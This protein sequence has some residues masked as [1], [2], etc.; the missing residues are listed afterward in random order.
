MTLNTPTQTR[1]TTIRT[2]NIASISAAL[3]TA[4]VTLRARS[5][6]IE[7]QANPVLW[8]HERL[9]IG[10]WSKQEEIANSIVVN[11]K[12]AVKSCNGVGKTFIAAVLT[13]WWID[14]HHDNEVLVVTTAPTDSQVKKLLW[15]YIRTIHRQFG[16]RGTVS[17]SAEWKSGDRDFIAYG[18]KPADTNMVAFQGAHTKYLLAIIDEAGGVPAS[19]WEGVDAITTIDTNR[20]LAIGNPDDPATEFGNIFLRNDETWNKITISALE[21]PNLTDEYK[22]LPTATT[23]NL[24]SRKWVE[25]KQ[26][27]WGVSDRRYKS[28]VLGEF[29]E[30]S[31][32]AL[33]TSQV[34]A[35]AQD[36]TPDTLNPTGTPRAGVLG[37]DVARFGT[38]LTVVVHNDGGHCSVPEGGSWS[39]LDTKS[40]AWKVHRLAID[41]GVREVRVDGVGVGAGVVDELMSIPQRNY[42]VVEVNGGGPSPDPS[43][44]YNYRAFI[45]DHL[46]EQMR[47]QQ[48]GIPE[49]IGP[50]DPSQII[51]DEL[52]GVRYKFIRGAMVI[53]SKD[54]IRKRGGKS[55][56]YADALTYAAAPF[57]IDDP[58]SNYGVG[59]QGA[60]RAEDVIQ[61][62]LFGDSLIIAPY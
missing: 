59:D 50:D 31:F 49:P 18:R 32:D 43:R 57:D 27:T 60:I 3:R 41:L 12:T 48:I 5:K 33:F 36:A 26:K 55:P 8:I 61:D 38:D 58:L 30:Q 24:V 1:D 44:W 56:D 29:P 52:R 35:A 6:N 15:G 54:D 47:T 40:S 11:K 20:I 9:G 2:S 37:V 16:L 53:E 22:N 25:D 14:V 7:Y 34:L 21:S 4:S 13:C 10:T 42:A 46:R 28:K 19:I 51:Q 39:K 23:E 17:E 45:Y 62:E